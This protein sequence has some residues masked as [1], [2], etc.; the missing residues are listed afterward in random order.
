MPLTRRE[1]VFAGAAVGA[2]AGAAVVVPVGL[3]LTDDDADISGA[4]GAQLASFPRTRIGSVSELGSGEPVFVDYPLEGQSNILVKLGQ[5]SIGGRGPDADIVAF[6]N[7]C[8]HMG[9]PITDYS[10]D[11]HVLGPCPCHFSSFDLSRDG[12][13]SFGQATQNLP[14]LLL[15]VEGDDIYASGVYRLIYGRSNNLGG[16][17]AVA[18]P[19]R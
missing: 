16:V 15:E 17:T 1:F 6:S 3:V 11:D 4:T 9:C 19:G 12:V 5:P 2:V 14:R 8:T 18:A 13:T 10:T 7:M